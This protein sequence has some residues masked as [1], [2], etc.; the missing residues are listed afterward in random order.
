MLLHRLIRSPG[1]DSPEQY[2]RR[3]GALAA[4]YLAIFAGSVAGG[5]IAAR[6]A[7]LLVTLAQR[8][9]VET[10]TLAFFL[11]FFA[12]LALI[13]AEGAWG[14]L[15]IGWYRA[16]ARWSGPEEAERRKQRL[17]SG[18]RRAEPA[19][20]AVNRTLEL[21]ERPAQPFTVPIRDAYGPC[22]RVIVDGARLTHDGDRQTGSNDLL[23]FFVGEVDRALGEDFG[24]HGLDVVLWQSGEEEALEA[25][26]SL[27]EFARALGVKLGADLW[28][29]RR[30]SA[31]QAARLERTLS[32]LCPALREEAL[33]PEWEFSGEHKLPIIPEPLGLLTLNVSEKRVDPLNTMGA[34]LVMVAISLG[35]LA[36]LVGFTPWVPSL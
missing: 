3:V 13:C 10:L 6:Q 8:S 25:Y 5:L 36:W 23:A 18:W 34:A 29:A 21:E 2:R 9:N 22:G 26:T 7:K 20:A 15:R 19:D 27:V 14:A 4:V 28:P 11:V 12:Y 31:A 30:L 1:V 32:Q 33:L 24:P 35:V 17:I 16:V